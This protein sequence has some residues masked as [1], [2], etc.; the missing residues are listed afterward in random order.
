MNKM[1]LIAAIMIALIS[2]TYAEKTGKEAYEVS[3]LAC[4][5]AN[6]AGGKESGQG[7]N[8]TIL[9]EDY[10][11]KQ[12]KNIRDG[13]RKG[14]GTI[15]MNKHLDEVAKLSA[16]ELEKAVKYALELPEAKAIHND[17]GNVDSGRLKYTMCGTCHGPKADG[18]VNPA[19]PA[20]RLKGQPNWYIVDSLKNFKVGH[21]GTEDAMAMQM[22]AM[23][24]TLPTEKDYED[25]AA[26]I[27]SLEK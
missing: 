11:R 19:I 24:M 21:R 10:F 4:H 5:G 16:P 15:N 3:C 17:K 9:K 7:P 22:K 18:Y 8:L 26:Y 14:P 6:G 23:T 13:K 1:T 25:V 27:K 2:T 12:F 20:P